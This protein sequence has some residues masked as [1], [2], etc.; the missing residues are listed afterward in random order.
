MN[1]IETNNNYLYWALLGRSISDIP[2]VT[3][4]EN[5]KSELLPL[6]NYIVTFVND[7]K[8]SYIKYNE[9]AYTYELNPQ[10]IFIAYCDILTNEELEEIGQYLFGILYTNSVEWKKMPNTKKFEHIKSKIKSLKNTKFAKIFKCAKVAKKDINTWQKMTGIGKA[11][12][13]ELIKTYSLADWILQKIDVESIKV[14][15]K[16]MPQKTRDLLANKMPEDNQVILYKL[17]KFTDE[18]IINIISKFAIEELLDENNYD[19]ICKIVEKT[20]YDNF[21]YLA[22]YHN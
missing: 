3:N 15:G 10:H 18:D 2:N 12:S 21:L 14:G 9:I 8:K 11:T 19:E 13:E 17:A 5:F 16:K 4:L 1:T 20:K 6:N 22:I 7:N